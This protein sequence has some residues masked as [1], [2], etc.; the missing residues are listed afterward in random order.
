[1]SEINEKNQETVNEVRRLSDKI[2]DATKELEALLKP[3]WFF[4]KRPLN[5]TIKITGLQNKIKELE[6]ER[7]RK[8]REVKPN[9]RR[10]M[11]GL[12]IENSKPPI[13]PINHEAA[14]KRAAEIEASVARF[15][16]IIKQ[17]ATREAAAKEA[18]KAVP[19]PG[20]KKG[21]RR[22]TRSKRR[23]ASTRRKRV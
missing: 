22:L 15:Q 14:A 4:S 5:T 17:A 3:T 9:T 6:K 20:S 10:I 7:R 1:M 16:N 13:I 23:A 2:K 18:A 21:G 11:A 12:P 19:N 8:I